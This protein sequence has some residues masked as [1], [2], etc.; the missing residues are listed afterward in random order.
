MLL[1]METDKEILDGFVEEIRVIE[2]VLKGIV[3][4]MIAS[5]LQDKALFEQYGQTI[6]RVYGTAATL[7]FNEL[8]EYTKALKDISY[9][10]SQSDNE[11]G[12]KKTTEMLILC[13]KY[14]DQICKGIH[15]PEELKKVRYL[16]S[17]DVSK[18][19][20]FCRSYFFSISRVSC[21]VE[22]KKA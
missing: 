17:V 13:L 7:G 14:L 18:A 11:K 20:K 15:D 2:K 4:K 6:D 10:C 9:K 3:Q 5:K 12:I 19:D 22:A 1:S 8:A 21:A 16:M